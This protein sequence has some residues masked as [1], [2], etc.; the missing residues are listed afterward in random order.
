M[1]FNQNEWDLLF[2]KRLA[3]NGLLDIAKE[4]WLRASD[5]VQQT[6]S[7]E[8]ELR[9]T[10]ADLAKSTETN[11]R[12]E[13]LA[14]EA[15]SLR[16][17]NSILDSRLNQLKEEATSNQKEIRRLQAVEQ[18]HQ[19]LLVDFNL[20]QQQVAEMDEWLLDLTAQMSCVVDAAQR[21]MRKDNLVR[22]EIE[23][24]AELLEKQ[25]KWSG[26][27]DLNRRPSANWSG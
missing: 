13:L 18:A 23:G 6:R 26:R 5:L 22:M 24:V 15:E 8:S 4:Q 27:S 14:A 21:T 3:N 10:R 12:L 20:V 2:G 25:P 7:L 1:K 19:A 11:H 16:K 9:K 17:G